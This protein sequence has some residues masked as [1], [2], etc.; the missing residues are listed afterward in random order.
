MT[1]LNLMNDAW[2]MVRREGGPDV[3]RPDQI[4]E[5]DVLHSDWPR[6]DLNLACLELLVGLVYMAA[7]PTDARDWR[8]GFDNWPRPE[9]LRQCFRCY[10][11]AF[12][13]LG[14]GPRFLQDFDADING[15]D[16]A[17]DMLFID[18]AG[19]NTI[20]K[21][22][23]LM[24]RRERYRSLPPNLAAMALYTLQDFAHEDGSGHRTS[25]RGGGPMVTLVK[26]P[27]SGLWPL[28]W[29]NVPRGRPLEPTEMAGKLPWMRP[30][31]TSEGNNETFPEG[32][33][34]GSPPVETF[35][36][37]P[38]RLRLKEER[39]NITGVTQKNYGT[40]YSGWSHP[41]TP[42]YRK[43]KDAKWSPKHPKQGFF[44]Y[45]NW[46]GVLLRDG[47]NDKTTRLPATLERFH[48]ER[49][50]DDCRLIVA[51]WAMRQ[52]KALEFKWSECPVFRLEEEQQDLAIDLIEKAGKIASLLGKSIR[53]ATKSS[54]KSSRKVKGDQV[55]AEN[56]AEAFYIQT[57]P[58]LEHMLGQIS[59]GRIEDTEKSWFSVIR[60][61]ALCL[62]DEAVLPEL[63][64]R[65]AQQQKNA[66]KARADM[67]KDMKK[68]LAGT[69]RRESEGAAS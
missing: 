40:K 44:S 58:C 14:D 63:A 12:N 19:E 69:R 56:A 60:R 15:K 4:V 22:K 29:A 57:Q 38:R 37:Q 34:T 62:F 46:Q 28:I 59:N 11:D 13:L 42:Y 17:V 26:P 51:G 9:T 53:N 65:S 33:D 50:G 61:E 2:I 66:A 8:D 23:D 39:G 5:D 35:F 47:G 52:A 32:D 10:A 3:I 68:S 54:E 64:E 16:V 1:N 43:K 25:M 7:P 24:V 18:S 20:K 49:E 6:P 36:G 48:R 45:T 41:L 27:E 30:T 55:K 67:I 21:N 31:R